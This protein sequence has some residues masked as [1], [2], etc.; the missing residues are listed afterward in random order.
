[1]IHV[2]IPEDESYAELG[3][4]EDSFSSVFSEDFSL[5]KKK[6]KKTIQVNLSAVGNG[7]PIRIDSW[8]CL[9]SV[10]RF[11]GLDARKQ[12]QPFQGPSDAGTEAFSLC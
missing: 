4:L 9:Q 6:K 8:A 10:G 5:Q 11:L 7:F 2:E 1:M 12:G 3:L